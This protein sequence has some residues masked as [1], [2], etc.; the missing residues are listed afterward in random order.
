MLLL[1]GYYP[2]IGVVYERKWHS[3]KGATGGSQGPGCSWPSFTT[4]LCGI[5]SIVGVGD[6]GE[7]K[8]DPVQSQSDPFSVP[9]ASMFGQQR[10]SVRWW[11]IVATVCEIVDVGLC[12]IKRT[13]TILWIRKAEE[14]GE[15]GGEWIEPHPTPCPTPSLMDAH[16]I[17]L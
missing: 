10:G 17:Q 1:Q 9:F 5:L 8:N 4:R 16:V 12:V 13:N 7:S 2:T 14:D 15:E 11:K 6:K 3:L